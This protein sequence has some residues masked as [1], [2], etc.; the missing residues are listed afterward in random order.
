MR[1]PGPTEEPAGR[2]KVVRHEE[3]LRTGRQRTVRGTVR[4]RKRVETQRVSEVVPREAE[5]LEVERVAAGPDDSGEIET[6]PD[7][8]LSVPV[9]AE[10]LVVT[11]RTVV[12]ERVILRKRRVTEQTVVEADLRRER[13]DVEADPEVRDRVDE[14]GG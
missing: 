4:V 11:R 1:E 14:I 2:A 3:E 8:S 10:E 9:L 6:L 5:R 7:G 13:V 12:R